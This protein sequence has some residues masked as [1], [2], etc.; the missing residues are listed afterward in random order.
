[1]WPIRNSDVKDTACVF[2][3]MTVWEDEKNMW[4]SLHVSFMWKQGSS[5]SV[6]YFP[7]NNE[8]AKEDIGIE[9]YQGKINK[10]YPGESNEC[11]A[12]KN[13][14]TNKCCELL[15]NIIPPSDADT[16]KTVTFW[17]E[18]LLLTKYNIIQI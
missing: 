14:S 11:S 1:M 13:F 18:S 4:L 15:K 12:V 2:H 9:V 7:Q 16:F 6:L 5:K 8:Y 3:Y 17:V 10:C